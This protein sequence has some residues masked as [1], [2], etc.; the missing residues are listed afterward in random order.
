LNGKELAL[1]LT[2]SRLPKQYLDLRRDQSFERYLS[3]CQNCD[4]LS[5]ID[6]VLIKK[7]A[8]SL[9]SLCLDLDPIR[10]LD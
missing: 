10:H 7:Q 6:Q 4:G 2:L 9:H 5:R 3:I 1:V 8:V